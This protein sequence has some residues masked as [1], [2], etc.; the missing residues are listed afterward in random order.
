MF[1]NSKCDNK[2]YDILGVS[3]ESSDG[4][5]KKAYRKKAMK[6]HPDKSTP[7]NKID[8]E[9][10]FKS[11]SHAYDVLKDSEKRAKYDRFGEEGLQ[12]MGGFEG[13]DPFDMFQSFFGGGGSPFG[14]FG[15]G[16]R[17]SQQVRRAD[18]RVE[19]I[20]IEL[21]DIYNKVTKKIDIKQKV[22]CIVC[23]GKGAEKESDIITCSQCNGKGK[24]M[25]IINIGPGMIQQ[26][27]TTCNKCSGKGKTIINKCGGCGGRKTSVKQK[28]INL[29]IESDFRTGKKIVIPEM[30]HYDPDCDEQGNLILVIRLNEHNIFKF[31]DKRN[32]HDLIM[33]KNILLS[34]ALC[35]AEFNVTHLDERSLMFKC[36]SII[37]PYQ[38]FLVKGEGMPYNDIMKGNLYINFNII[39]P[40]KLDKERIKYLKKLLP[41]KSD[42]ETIRDINSCQE[43]KFI[44][45][46]G[47]K[48]NMEEVNLDNESDH[49]GQGNANEGVECVHQ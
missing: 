20:H 22:E 27:M 29:P 34:E 18:D 46:A 40:E 4:D 10:K 14:G 47:E 7:D 8:N 44:E 21:E 12:G 28:I 31:K 32:T 35:G 30:A 38:E 41:V 26:S 45:C 15:G 3:K 48:I 17:R 39:Y 6:Y 49:T 33:D 23:R 11:V 16:G 24:M 37:K 13:G 2:L 43:I 42:E 36:S 25:R 9:N 1:Q 5:I 19:E